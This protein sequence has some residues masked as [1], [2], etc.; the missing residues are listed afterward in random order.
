[1]INSLYI[2]FSFF[3]ELLFLKTKFTVSC[4]SLEGKFTIINSPCIESYTPRKSALGVFY[5]QL[6]RDGCI[7]RRSENSRSHFF[8]FYQADNDRTL[9]WALPGWFIDLLGH[10][11]GCRNFIWTWEV[12]MSNFQH[13]CKFEQIGIFIAIYLSKQ[14][15]LRGLSPF[16]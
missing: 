9:L 6:I 4:S 12:K 2:F 14:K 11:F 1:M 15:L 3:K 5:S 7:L 16:I 13:F 10:I 8:K